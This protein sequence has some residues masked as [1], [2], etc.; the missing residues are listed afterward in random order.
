M[1]ILLK[2]VISASMLSLSALAQY[3]CGCSSNLYCSGALTIT[4][5]ATTCSKACYCQLTQGVPF[6]VP[7][8]AT[9]TQLNYYVYLNSMKQTTVTASV[10]T[11][12]VPFDLNSRL[13]PI[14]S[15]VSS[16]S[17]GVF[18]SYV[19]QDTGS[20]SIET[21]RRFC[22]ISQDPYY[23]YQSTQ[24]FSFTYSVPVI[25]AASVETASSVLGCPVPSPTESPIAYPTGSPAAYPTAYPKYYPTGS[26]AAYPTAYPFQGPPIA[27]PSLLNNFKV[28]VDPFSDT[29]CGSAVSPVTVSNGECVQYSDIADDDQFSQQSA[30]VTC[31]SNNEQSS[32]TLVVYADSICTRAS[33]IATMQ[34]SGMCQCDGATYR[35]Y[36]LSVL[37]NCAGIAPSCTFMTTNSAGSSSGG[38]SGGEIGGIVVGVL[39]LVG[40]VAA[41]MYY[42]FVR[43]ASAPMES[44]KEEDVIDMTSS[45]AHNKA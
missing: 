19:T 2:L 23:T 29:S 21:I 11:A 5:G 30:I 22:T 44:N 42:F 26:P 38:V 16:T 41:A 10:P 39:A 8:V 32:W 14:S 12:S 34:G 24:L 35:G 28:S 9:G 3:V 43:K 31:S 33:A 1:S 40:I 25:L 4:N 45:P 37:V 36:S 7:Y 15:A 17:I 13:S 6:T 27:S 20:K 18:V